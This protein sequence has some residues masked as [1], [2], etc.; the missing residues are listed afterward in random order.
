[1]ETPKPSPSSVSSNA[2]V[3]PHQA[4]SSSVDGMLRTIAQ[5]PAVLA[6][7]V[8]MKQR[9]ALLAAAQAAQPRSPVSEQ[10]E[11]ATTEPRPWRTWLALGGIS[12]ALATA[13]LVLV[14]RPPT[15]LVSN[16]VA[17]TRFENVNRLLVPETHA[18]DFFSVQAASAQE[19]E[20]EDGLV[21]TSR[22]PL[23]ADQV[24]AT[25]QV[26][27][28][29]PIE[30]VKLASNTFKV[31]PKTTAVTA[32][33]YRISLPTLVANPDGSR[34]VKEYSWS[35]QP[36]DRL[37]VVSTLPGNAA[38][39]VPVTTGI[40]FTLNHVGLQITSSTI[41]LTPPTE[42]RIEMR[43]QTAVFI[44]AKPLLPGTLYEARLH[45]IK[46]G[47]GLTLAEEKRIRFETA[48]SDEQSEARTKELSF[49]TEFIEAVPNREIRL[50][51]FKGVRATV[52]D[53][54]IVGY[55]VSLDE[56]RT[57]LESRLRVPSWSEQA[58]RQ[59]VEY[60]PLARQEAFHA[61]VPV[62]SL[63]EAQGFATVTLPTLSQAGFYLLRLQIPGVEDRW[64]FLQLTRIASYTSAD[65]TKVL[66]WAVNA[67]T[68]KPFAQ[69]QLQ[70]AEGAAITNE[71]GVGQL[72][73]PAFLTAATGMPEDESGVRVVT[74]Q[75]GTDQALVA[76]T[77]TRTLFSF[78]R[79]QTALMS[80]WG[81][82]FADR[83]LYHTTDE[84]HFAGVTL[85]RDT[86]LP[87]E[88][89][90]VRI[91]RSQSF[92]DVWTG[93]PKI[94]QDVPLTLDATGHFQGSMSWS[95]LAP[96]YYSV[97]LVRGNKSVVERSFEVR[98]FTKPAYTI[99]VT[100]GLPRVYA[101]QDI[102]VSIQARF[103]DG[104]PFPKAA[105]RLT[106]I[107][108]GQE[109]E[110]R[111]VVVDAQGSAQIIVH[112]TPLTCEKAEGASCNMMEPLELSVR[113]E[114]GEEG[115]IV[116][117]AFVEVFAS[118]IDLRASQ[119]VEN[120]KAIITLQARDRDLRLTDEESDHAPVHPGLEVR[121][122]AIGYYYEAIPEGTYYDFI[123]K[124]V[125]TSYRY[126]RRRDAQ[127]TIFRLV[128]DANGQ[129]V[130]RFPLN[131]A[132]DYYEISLRGADAKQHPV[133][134]F[135][136]VSRGWSDG[137]GGGEVSRAPRLVPPDA[138]ANHEMR[139]GET[140]PLTYLHG[141]ETVDLT[142][143]PGLLVF[144]A[145]RGIRDV[146]LV[147]TT[148]IPTTFDT[149][150]L[151]NAEVHAVTFL[152]GHFETAQ[153]TL[154][155]KKSD[156]AL[157][158]E[159]MP[160]RKQVHPGD[161]IT[162]NIHVTDSNGAVPVNTQVALA[163]V[164]QA[165][166]ALTG[167]QSEDPLTML[168]DLVPSG[169]R[170]LS[171]SHRDEYDGYS[172]GGAE[173]GGMG[174][175]DRTQAA[176][177]NFKDTA[178]FQIVSLDAQGNAEVSFTAPDN[179]TSWHL[180]AVAY[181]NDLAAG[182]GTQ[183][184]A[185]GRTAFAEVVL[186][187]RL[188]VQDSPVLSVRAFGVGVDASSTIAFTIDAPTLGIQGVM[189]TG[190]ALVPTYFAL[191]KLVPGTH[192]VVVT[193]QTPVGTDTL[194]RSVTVV[195]FF[196][197]K[198]VLTAI[199]A[200]PGV[201]LP[202]LGEPETEVM[203]AGTG[204]AAL[205]PEVQALAGEESSRLDARVARVLSQDLLSRVYQLPYAKEE[206]DAFSAYQADEPEKGL[207]LLPYGS[208]DA[209][210]T[211]EVAMTAPDLFD[212]SLLQQAL[213]ATL[214]NASSTRDEQIAALAALA[215]LHQPVVSDLAAFATRSDLTVRQR[216]WMAEGLWQAG[217][218]KTAQELVS[219]LLTQTVLVD[220]QRYLN[221]ARLDDRISLTAALA[222]VSADLGRPEAESLYAYVASTW[223]Q[224]AFP[225]LAKIRYLQARLRTLPLQD[226]KITWTTNGV[227]EE[228]MDLKD[229]PVRFFTLTAAEAQQFRVRAVSGGAR[230][231]L[232]QT[233]PGRPLS[234]PEMQIT[235]S[236]AFASSTAGLREGDEVTVA[237]TP[238]W[239]EAARPGC[240]LIRDHVP[241][242]WQPVLRRHV[243]RPQYYVDDFDPRTGEISFIACKQGG[244]ISLSYQARVVTRGI[245]TA[246]APIMEHLD[247]PSIVTVG[248]DEKLTVR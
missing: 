201:G 172:A 109:R 190:T 105:L 150:Y 106:L 91:M 120:G 212:A 22:V 165:L 145:A 182:V 195:N 206:T 188:L 4:A 229:E 45:T 19:K 186:P 198:H 141:T 233:Q 3:P 199:D 232:R 90:H 46:T 127:P 192:K 163:A 167:P 74:L 159:V 87:P 55:P 51:I 100:P 244:M 137:R 128:T 178:T 36:Q 119:Q 191:K 205:L 181:S 73:A 126:E 220:G 175:G 118:S 16:G 215:S 77:G 60:A 208:S 70:S 235:R 214:A 158:V 6:S 15:P 129:A 89:M 221:E 162:V 11:K 53:V 112:P 152:N 75:R 202:S 228:S 30:V 43:G 207:R 203:I 121:G 148:T 86:H 12:C 61:R 101:D 8:K 151:P 174:L 134:A 164:D 133:A 122:E 52:K 234:V 209:L 99:D 197:T 248:T 135:V 21:L 168:Y 25:I 63:P 144:T 88:D 115:E 58:R 173:M 231:I 185:V 2:P 69:V 97:V 66:I 76:L 47:A 41:T 153:A 64:A 34:E 29:V 44:P 131:P 138:Q 40:E 32:A 160:V 10:K 50:G 247:Y 110:S 7:E 149:S 49:A 125:R 42:G 132:R 213:T 223:N 65:N 243:V 216:L 111:E 211:A 92:I 103:F 171:A 72:P 166:Y 56:A 84:L 81:Y 142:K 102:P 210:L 31:I 20:G 225:V 194:E 240:Y 237:L 143:T 48:M 5:E 117:S 96:G 136:T 236:Y 123:Q 179:I 147:S 17:V 184:V 54:D 23:T 169:L 218:Q 18:A 68:N 139:V 187:P 230:I 57:L 113:P 24:K 114:S 26:T 80:T 108:G 38:T 226:G 241:G 196:F 227:T 83:P 94:Y 224:E 9:A 95:S 155:Y 98:E 217:D 193:I 104:T 124:E 200:A 13:A 78:G 107:Q 189:A 146:T 79:D 176:R 71:Q 183:D 27:P 1:M 156:K 39:Y 154:L 219:S 180:T 161:Q 85:D 238:I 33:S 130:Y 37:Q 177:R 14:L 62:Q 35:L 67:E 204:R 242:G 140:V 157:A 116:G 93:K 28:P 59:F 82:L 239:K 170:V 222:A 246:E 245:Y